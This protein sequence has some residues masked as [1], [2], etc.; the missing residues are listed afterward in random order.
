[1]YEF[2][3][4]Q[5]ELEAGD[6]A[7][8]RIVYLWARGSKKA[9]ESPTQDSLMMTTRRGMNVTLCHPKGYDLDA[10]VMRVCRRNAE[11]A[12]SVGGEF[13]VTDDL[14][15][16]SKDQDIVYA[17]HWGE[18]ATGERW[19]RWYCDDEVLGR[20][21]FIHPMP[22][23][24]DVEACSSVVG[25]EKRSMIRAIEKNKYFLQKAA[26]ALLVRSRAAV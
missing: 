16:A 21:K 13:T 5:D 3:T 26:L 9:P 24:R 17:R 8:K 6:L 20:A 12:Q 4:F 22:I 10:D 7:G 11:N 2:M 14:A 23:E 15:S 18:P 19:E 25:D 1:M